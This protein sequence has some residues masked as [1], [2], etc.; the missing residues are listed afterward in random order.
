MEDQQISVASLLL[1]LQPINI[2]CIVAYV[3]LKL[4]L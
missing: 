1:K 2:C 3:I 4:K